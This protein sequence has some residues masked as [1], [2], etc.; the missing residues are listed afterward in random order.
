MN[1]KTFIES[2]GASCSN[3][4]WS[5]SFVNHERKFVIFGVWEGNEEGGKALLLGQKWEYSNRGRKQPGYKQALAHIDLVENHKYLLKTFPMKYSS[6]AEGDGT[7]PSK[8]GSF[9]P[10]L[11]P[12]RLTQSDG[13]WYAL[14]DNP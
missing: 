10:K 7:G 4:T 8:I 1:R 6:D 3:W 5:W 14:D 11:S 2:T 13:D 9:T 12:K